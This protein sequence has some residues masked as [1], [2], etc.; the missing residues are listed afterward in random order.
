MTA[1]AIIQ[2]IAAIV[3]LYG[4]WWDARL[5]ERT[6][7][8]AIVEKLHQR[9]MLSPEAEATPAERTGFPFSPRQNNTF[10]QWLS[11]AG[12]NWRV[13]LPP[14][15]HPWSRLVAWCRRDPPRFST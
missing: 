11:E 8:E 6:R 7:R 12:E 5:R 2:A 10:N 13:P 14:L 9:W 3:F 4:V 15:N 1:A